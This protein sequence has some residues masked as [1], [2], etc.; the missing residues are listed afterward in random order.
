MAALDPGVMAPD[1]T[2]PSSAGDPVTLSRYRGKRQVVLAFYP[3]DW[4]GG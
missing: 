1:F 2:L 3:L 4:T